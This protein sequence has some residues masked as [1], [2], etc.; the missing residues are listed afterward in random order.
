MTGRIFHMPRD[1]HREVRSLLP[2]Y[3]L[4]GLDEVET[5]LVKAHVSRCGQCQAELGDESQ[6]AA[7]IVDLPIGG[8]A[9][10][11]DHGWRLISRAMDLEPPRRPPAVAWIERFIPRSAQVV[12]APRKESLWLGWALAVQLCLLL[13]LGVALLRTTQPGRFHALGAAPENAAGNIIVVFNPQTA[14]KDFRAI[15]RANNARLVD[16][17]MVTDAYLIHVATSD[18][19]EVLAR[20]RRQPQV[21]LAEP[22][23]AGPD[24]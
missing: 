10:D 11:A 2:W 21:V 24:R 20:L 23:N 12:R 3:R 8:D 4:G 6:L 15:L 16:G 7:A 1:P 17:P 22:V 5:A 13:V 14:E 19:A 9:S 18:R